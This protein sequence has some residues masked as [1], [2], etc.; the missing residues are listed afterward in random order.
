MLSL[1]KIQIIFHFIIIFNALTSTCVRAFPIMTFQNH[2]DDSQNSNSLNSI[3][4][5]QCS[6]FQKCGQTANFEAKTKA[7]HKK[8][9]KLQKRLEKLYSKFTDFKKNQKINSQK[10][11]EKNV[12]KIKKLYSE[13]NLQK[14]VNSLIDERME[15]Y[16]V[17]LEISLFSL[18]IFNQRQ[19][20]RFLKNMKL[21]K[22]RIFQMSSIMKF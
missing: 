18:K 12:R 14:L 1:L 17:V 4:M 22:I 7:Q 3:E 19:I 20:L 21:F 8:L 15:K 9:L 13:D 11:L 10:L 5:D 6:I 2:F 16:R